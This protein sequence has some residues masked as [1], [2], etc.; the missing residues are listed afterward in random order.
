MPVQGT[1]T[2]ENQFMP[3][4]TVLI[5]DDE[6]DVCEMLERYLKSKGYEVSSAN[7]GR[8]ALEKVKTF[9]PG[10]ALLDIRMPNMDGVECL[11]SI[12]K[13]FPDTEVI[14][15]TASK[16][17]ATAIS[18]MKEGAYGYQT[19][20]IDL[21]NLAFDI[22]RAIEHRRLI[23]ENRDYQVNLEKKVVERTREV[24]LLNEKLK[25]SFIATIRISSGLVEVYDPFLG[26]H[27]KRVARLS[28][29]VGSTMKLSNAELVDLEMAALLHELGM[30]T[31][32]EQ[33]RNAPLKELKTEE[34]KII[35]NYPIL[36]QAILSPS[37][38]LNKAGVIIRHHLEHINGT[39]FPDSKKGEDI[40]L[41]SKILGVVNAYDEIATR[42]RFTSEKFPSEKIKEDFVFLQLN[43]LAGKHYE[44]NII[45]ILEGVVSN[46]IRKK[47][48]RELYS[49]DELKHGMV[50]AS[51]IHSRDGK[52]LL[53]EG[54][55]ISNIQLIKIQTFY[56]MKLLEQKIYVLDSL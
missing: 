39:G 8:E 47:R 55:I 49:S 10:V 32:P 35:R 31:I 30:I 46:F 44:K 15:A 48:I 14:M 19:K 18:C 53:A 17:M 12:K 1:G 6:K 33:I 27:S 45:N 54:S 20:P 56:R 21:S 2:T 9:K 51:D 50:L 22:E 34:V 13:D 16:D 52:L 5:V 40:P 11:R 29:K 24:Q 23:L 25:E 42:R 26:G 36:S 3:K 43:Q 41:G 38:E 7:D 28:A 4:N 37:E